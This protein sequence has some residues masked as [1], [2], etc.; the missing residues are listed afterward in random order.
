MP[1]AQPKTRT[2]TKPK[3]KANN[4]AAQ[5]LA[6]KKPAAKKPNA[7]KSAKPVDGAKPAPQPEPLPATPVIEA[8]QAPAAKPQTPP[9]QHPGKPEQPMWAR[10]NHGHSQKMS[11]G[12]NFR[13]QGR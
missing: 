7:S 3:A 1:K 2:R 11:K 4:V 5:K 13:H 8:T 9:P 12:R 10:F 6:A